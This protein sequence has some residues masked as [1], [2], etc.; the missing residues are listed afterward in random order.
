MASPN[1]RELTKDECATFAT[2]VATTDPHGGEHVENYAYD[3][4]QRAAVAN[5]GDLD[6]TFRFIARVFSPSVKALENIDPDNHFWVTPASMT[7]AEI[8]VLKQLWTIENDVVRARLGDYLW[9]KT[10]DR[11]YAEGA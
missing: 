9:A 1:V 4:A 11:Q 2:A 6:F 3:L 5:D 7:D 8:A 10:R